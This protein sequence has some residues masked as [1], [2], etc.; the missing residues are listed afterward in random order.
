MGKEASVMSW[1]GTASGC[2]E[3]RVPGGCAGMK[4]GDTHGGTERGRGGW[5]R[6]RKVSALCAPWDALIL[7]TTPSRGGRDSVL[8]KEMEM[9]G[10]FC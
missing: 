6:A 4:M 1:Q 8:Q 10:I 2:M 3:K 5:L 7:R 9:A